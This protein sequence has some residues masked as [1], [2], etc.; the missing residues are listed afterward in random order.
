MRNNENK[1]DF[2]LRPSLIWAG[3]IRDSGKNDGNNLDTAKTC[4][5]T[6]STRNGDLN[7]PTPYEMEGTDKP[8]W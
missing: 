5:R 8:P 2:I 7:D 3:P 1:N 6:D 4:W